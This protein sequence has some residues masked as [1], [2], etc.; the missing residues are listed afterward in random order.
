MSFSQAHKLFSFRSP[1]VKRQVAE[2]LNIV[3]KTGN[4][5]QKKAS[6]IIFVFHFN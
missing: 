1:E 5:K 6:E 3:K 2:E 4:V